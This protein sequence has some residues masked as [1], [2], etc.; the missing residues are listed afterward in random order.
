MT[1]Q[2]ILKQLKDISRLMESEIFHLIDDNQDLQY[3]YDGNG[4]ML[5]GINEAINI[6][7]CSDCEGSGLVPSRSQDLQC[8]WYDCRKCNGKGVVK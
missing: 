2:E 8:D 4:T 7:Q 5:K 6:I 3:D 1:K